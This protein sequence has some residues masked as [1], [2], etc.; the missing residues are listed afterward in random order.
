AAAGAEPRMRHAHRHDTA[1]AWSERIRAAVQDERRLPFQH[2]EAFL[3]GMDV[4]LDVAARVEGAQAEPHV[5]RPAASIDQ[6]APPQGSAVLDV[7]RLRL[8]LWRPQD[9]MH[10]GDRSRSLVAAVHPDG[11]PLNRSLSMNNLGRTGLRKA[12]KLLRRYNFRRAP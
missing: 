1:R 9:V 7:L 12:R 4:R 2:V 6:R 3:E 10:R 11:T 8:N 5:H